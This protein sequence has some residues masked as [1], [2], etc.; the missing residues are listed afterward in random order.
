MCSSDPTFS[1]EHRG[2]P[3]TGPSRSLSLRIGIK[4][5]SDRT[6][7][8]TRRSGIPG[9]GGRP[10]GSDFGSPDRASGQ[11]RIRQ[12]VI[13]VTNSSRVSR[14]LAPPAERRRAASPAVH[15]LSIP[16]D[17][18]PAACQVSPSTRSARSTS[19][20][21]H[22][23]RSCPA[24]SVSRAGVLLAPKGS[25]PSRNRR[26]SLAI[27]AW[28]IPDK[29]PLCPT[30]IADPDPVDNFVVVDGHLNQRRWGH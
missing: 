2:P 20:S 11:G 4:A 1:L 18:R 15:G 23:A 21:P 28:F 22:A 30:A 12:R 25:V 13:P 9:E 16:A 8:Y 29:I 6:R 27:S 14:S 26:A 5:C 7:S 10:I 3:G 19:G 24:S 17:G